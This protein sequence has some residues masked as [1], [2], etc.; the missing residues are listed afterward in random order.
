LL[1]AREKT[2]EAVLAAMFL[3]VMNPQIVTSSVAQYSVKPEME[4]LSQSSFGCLSPE[5]IRS[6]SPKRKLEFIAGRFCALKA[7]ERLGIE[8]C[9]EIGVRPNRSPDWPQGWIGSITHTDGFASAAV[10]SVDTLRGLGIDSER[11]MS[12]ETAHEVARFVLLPSE[13]VLW[14]RLLRSILSFESYVTLVFS[15]KESAYKCFNTIAGR[16]FDFHDVEILAVHL[17]TGIIKFKIA[18][19][20]SISITGSTFEGRFEITPQFIHTAVELS[21]HDYGRQERLIK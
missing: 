8:N 4:A 7:F 9:P 2:K 11:V 14:K 1:S 12:P 15:A 17:P 3:S 21:S 6:F 13:L 5:R 19:T 20:L 16:F 18:Q 10:A